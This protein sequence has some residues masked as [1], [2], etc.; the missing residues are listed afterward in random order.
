[1]MYEIDEQLGGTEP[2]LIIVPVGVGSLAQ[3]VVT[4]YEASKGR[5]KVLTVECDSAPCLYRSLKE[6]EEIS[7]T[8]NFSIM[9]G[10]NYGSLSHKAWSFL[11]NG[12]DA[13]LTVGD[14]EVHEACTLL[15]SLGIHAGPCGAASLAALQRLS[16]SDREA[17][18]L[19]SSSI[20]ILLCTERSRDYAVPREESST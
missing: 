2:Y 12:V 10:L 3:S 6:G 14:V 17:L 13:A 7:I 4:H 11:Q 18:G 16:S 19:D 8:P 5:S 1:M 9:H 15:N 20:V